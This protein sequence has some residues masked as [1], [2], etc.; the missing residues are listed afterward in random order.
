MT[1]EVWTIEGK[2]TWTK[3]HGGIGSLGSQKYNSEFLKEK[4]K[5]K[6]NKNHSKQNK[7]YYHQGRMPATRSLV[8]RTA[9]WLTELRANPASLSPSQNLVTILQYSTKNGF[10]QEVFPDTPGPKLSCALLFH[11]RI[12]HSWHWTPPCMS[13]VQCLSGLFYTSESQG[14]FVCVS[15]T[16]QETPQESLVGNENLPVCRALG[17]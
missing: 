7:P 9:S 14:P 13:A 8:M 11:Y 10:I 17:E 3:D 15:L 5:Q 16:S 4:Q 6:Q 12:L 1:Q 2:L